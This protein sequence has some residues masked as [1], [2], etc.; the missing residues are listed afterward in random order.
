M[1]SWSAIAI[2]IN[3]HQATT[4]VGSLL[5]PGPKPIGELG[6]GAPPR[7]PFVG[8]FVLL[9]GFLGFECLHLEDFEEKGRT[10]AWIYQLSETAEIIDLRHI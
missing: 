1:L 4:P 10:K 3:P 9:T 5:G 2:F 6:G 7:R 8:N